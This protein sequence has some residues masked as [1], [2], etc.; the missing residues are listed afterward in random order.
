MM[1][2]VARLRRHASEGGPAMAR[3]GEHVWVTKSHERIRGRV[4]RSSPGLVKLVT[5]TPFQEPLRPRS[6]VELEWLDAGGLAQARGRVAAVESGPP[7]VAEI[8]LRGRPK[9]IERRN[10]LRASADL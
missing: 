8:K 10:E 5:A 3:E 2:R 6:K 4:V 7:P 9:A 1:T